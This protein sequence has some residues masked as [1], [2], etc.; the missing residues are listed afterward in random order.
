MQKAFT[1]M[2]SD[3]CL[4]VDGT[5]IMSRSLQFCFS[6]RTRKIFHNRKCFHNNTI[7]TLFQFGYLKDISIILTSIQKNFNNK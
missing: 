6:Q 3:F 2:E 5:A 7:R 4:V 1:Q